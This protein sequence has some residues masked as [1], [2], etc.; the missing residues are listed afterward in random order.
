MQLGPNATTAT[1]AGPD[2]AD[3]GLD[4]SFVTLRW[5]IPSD[6]RVTLLGE[7]TVLL[8][9][10]ETAT[11]RL[12]TA[13]V[14]RQ[15]AEVKFDGKRHWIRDLSS[16]NGVFVNAERVREAAIQ[17]GD[18]VR[19]GDAIAVVEIVSSA[20]LSGFGEIAPGVLGGGLLRSLVSR[21]RRIATA[22]LNVVLLGETGTGK[23]CFARALHASSGRTGPFLAVNCAAYDESTVTAELFGYRRGAFTGAE[24]ANAGHLRAAE[25]G[26]LFLDEVLELS[27]AIQ[28]K[29]LR[30][31]E[32]KEVLSLGETKPRSIDVRFLAAS[33]IPLGRAVQA[34][35][36][37]RD[38]RAR[39]EG[40]VIELPN[41]CARRGDVVPLFLQLLVRHGQK[42]VP[43]LDAKLAE[44]LCLYD[45]PMNVRELENVARRVATD[46]S[47]RSELAFDQ[48]RECL[49]FDVEL[50]STKRA[51]EPLPEAAGLPP[52]EAT[53][54]RGLAAYGAEELDSLR[55]ALDL[56]HGSVRRAAE[57]LGI[58]RP[59]AYRMLRVMQSRACP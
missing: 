24:S 32:Q 50:A 19:L 52:D 12:E 8:G 56:H 40:S 51:R 48:V 44:R 34:G 6:N 59:R 25:G 55:R 29:L 45:W 39:L 33:Q 10:D 7:E 28:A 35:V 21:A 23:E 4:A 30:A 46:H 38:L 53:F 3:A 43:L 49:N 26:T 13:Q 42:S 17:V 1:A 22:D 16:K 37:R 36:F 41:L 31:I 57:E 20:G 5:V 11:T 27:A 47:D 58:S 9:R 15:H 54:R 2:E 18:V 14:S